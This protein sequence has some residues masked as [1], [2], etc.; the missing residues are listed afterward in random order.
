MI[1]ENDV[2]LLC[3]ILDRI[4]LEDKEELK[5]EKRLNLIKK[6]IEVQESMREQLCEIQ[7]EINA[8][9]KDEE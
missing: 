8:V 6:Q 4:N 2:K 7:D 5:L 1:N 9:M 3:V